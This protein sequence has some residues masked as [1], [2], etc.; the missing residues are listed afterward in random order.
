MC[1]N[2]PPKKMAIIE[3][4]SNILI[5]RRPLLA[6]DHQAVRDHFNPSI[7]YILLV[8]LST[9]PY[10]LNLLFSCLVSP[11]PPRPQKPPPKPRRARIPLLFRLT[12][13]PKPHGTSLKNWPGPIKTR[14]TS[15]KSAKM[16]PQDGQVDPQDPQ[17]V[18]DILQIHQD[19]TPRWPS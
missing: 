14:G 1:P 12:G 11:L 4:T 13:P 8:Y 15:S 10:I 16:A 2:Y 19:G 7:L 3:C 9:Y 6:R 5:I 17:N 18:W